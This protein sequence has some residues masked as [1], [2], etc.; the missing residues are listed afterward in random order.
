MKEVEFSSNF[1][2]GGNRI[3]RGGYEVYK[4]LDF[5]QRQNCILAYFFTLK[6]MSLYF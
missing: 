1:S 6:Y 5:L 4:A 2:Y 3:G